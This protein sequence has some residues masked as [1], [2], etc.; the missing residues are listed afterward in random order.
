MRLLKLAPATAAALSGAALLVL[1]LAPL[2]TGLGWWDFRFGLYSMMPASGY[3]AAAA[4]ILAIATLALGWSRVRPRGRLLLAAALIMG[5]VLAYVPWNYQRIRSTLPPIHDITTDTDNPPAFAAVLP[6][7]AAENSGSV[8]YDRAQLPQLQRQAYS[9]LAPITA[10]VPVAKAFDHALAVARTMPGWTIVAFDA[11]AGRIE[12]SQQSRW[13]RFTDDVVIRIAGDEA[14]SR[15]DMRST[16]RQGR[17]DYGVNAA[18][19][20]AYMTALRQRLG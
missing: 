5:A 1:A 9:D 16:S 8:V 19:I 14:G 3:V 7:R 4:V 2:G 12:A 13:F 17:S 11:G 18:R 10:T 15:I 20:R 6:A